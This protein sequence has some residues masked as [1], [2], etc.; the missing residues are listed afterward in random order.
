MKR[1]KFAQLVPSE[2]TFANDPSLRSDRT[3][4]ILHR[5]F[6]LLASLYTFGTTVNVT[7]QVMFYGND[8][9]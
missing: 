7:Y 5:W 2:N 6:F 3:Y 9:I 8:G 4:I 1:L